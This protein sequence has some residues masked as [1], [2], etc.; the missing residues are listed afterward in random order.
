MRKILKYEFK[1]YYREFFILGGIVIALALVGSSLLV[2]SFE[3]ISDNSSVGTFTS[4]FGGIISTLYVFSIMAMFIVWLKLVIDSLYK[5]LFTNEGYL[6]FTL[7]VSVDKLLISKLIAGFVWMLY[8]LVVIF[9]S[10]FI[11]IIVITRFEIQVMAIIS[12]M[13]RVVLQNPLIVLVVIFMMVLSTLLSIVLILFVATLM[14]SKKGSKSFTFVSIILYFAISSGIDTIV[15]IFSLVSMGLA[16]DMNTGNNF[17]YFSNMYKIIDLS[18]K[19]SNLEEI[20][21]IPYCSFNQLIIY[22]GAIVGFYF[23]VRYL[24]SHKLELK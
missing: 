6:T 13:F 2:L 17:V 21:Y 16:V 1:N 19:I 14:H 4:I 23:L 11:Y 20:V 8:C 9:L 24:I 15:Q 10:F 12:E 5:K 3:S 18:G 7:P 22:I